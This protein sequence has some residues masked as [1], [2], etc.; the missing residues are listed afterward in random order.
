MSSN[1]HMSTHYT[2]ACSKS[3]DQKVAKEYSNE[4]EMF[5]LCTLKKQ[6]CNDS[7]RI[8]LRFGNQNHGNYAW[9]LSK[10]SY[11][12]TR[13]WMRLRI[14]PLKYQKNLYQNRVCYTV[15]IWHK[16]TCFKGLNV[17][18]FQ[19]WLHFSRLV[20]SNMGWRCQGSH[21]CLSEIV[22]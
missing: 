16:P 18:F 7:S 1:I 17:R 13:F 19:V 4:D 11:H 5:A 20:S 14:V 21:Q 15:K 22:R 3:L 8:P 10:R 9:K 6:N 12:G 2:H